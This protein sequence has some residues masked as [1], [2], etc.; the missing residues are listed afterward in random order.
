S[1][2]TRATSRPEP[3][4]RTAPS[5]R[6]PLPPSWPAL[7]RPNGTPGSSRP[8]KPP[9]ARAAAHLRRSAWRHPTERRGGNAR[10]VRD[11]DAS[12]R[13]AC[14]GR[15]SPAG[16]SVARLWTRRLPTPDRGYPGRRGRP[17]LGQEPLRLPRR[18]ERDD[19]RRLRRARRRVSLL[20]RRLREHVRGEPTP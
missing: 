2:E 1:A 14:G 18:D 15:V 6:G 20:D 5:S 3:E 12:R 10:H 9:L 17:R 19:L 8:A 11:A 16:A 7:A 13:P 4:P